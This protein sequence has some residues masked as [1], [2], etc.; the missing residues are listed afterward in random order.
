MKKVLYFLFIFCITATLGIGSVTY[1]YAADAQTGS[2]GKNI[3]YTL[4]DG[5]LNIVGTGEIAGLSFKNNADVKSVIISEG[6]TAIGESAFYECTNLS[7]VSFPS[8]LKTLCSSAFERCYS[9]DNVVFP[10]SVKSISYSCFGACASCTFTFEGDCPAISEK[11]FWGTDCTFRVPDTW[12]DSDMTGHDSRSARYIGGFRTL[13]NIRYSERDFGVFLITGEGSIPDNAFA[14]R[15]DIQKITID[16]GITSVGNGAFKNCPELTE[17]ILL[18]TVTD[19]GASAFEECKKLAS[20]SPL[21]GITSIGARA[22]AECEALKTPEFSVE[23]AL[24]GENAFF[25]CKNLTK[26]IL[27]GTLSAIEREAFRGC[28]SLKEVSIAE[29]TETIGAYAFY[30]CPVSTLRLPNSVINIEERAF[31]GCTFSSVNIPAEL[32]AIGDCAF[33]SCSNLKAVVFGD[34]LRTIGMAAFEKCTALT[35]VSFNDGLERLGSDAFARCPVKELKLPESL[36]FIGE[37]CFFDCRNVRSLVIPN[38][39][40]EI[41][42]GAFQAMTNLSSITL[43]ENL[44]ELKTATFCQCTALKEL[45]LPAS[46]ERMNSDVFDGCTNLKILR[47]LGT[48]PPAT[49]STTF[50]SASVTTVYVPY[51]TSMLYSK[52]NSWNKLDIISTFSG[53]ALVPG[54][55]GAY[56]IK[57]DKD[58]AVFLHSVADGNSYSGKTIRLE[59]DIDFSNISHDSLWRDDKRKNP[60]KGSFLGYGHSISNLTISSGNHRLGLFRTV[61]DGAVIQDLILENVIVEASGTTDAYAALAGYA[62]GKIMFNNITVQSGRIA[63][64]NYVGGIAGEVEGSKPV[65]FLY[66]TNYA[67]VVASNNDAAGILAHSG[68]SGGI[69]LDTCTNYGEI[70][71]KAGHSGGI[72]GYLGNNNDDPAQTVQSCLNF[73]KISTEGNAGG[74]VGGVRTDSKGHIIHANENY[75]DVSATGTGSYAGGIIGYHEGGGVISFN[76]SEANI[77]SRGRE[78]GGIVAALEDDSCEFNYNSNSGNVT[79]ILRVGGII[80]YVGD[81]EHD[82]AFKFTNCSNSGNIISETSDAGGIIGGLCTDSRNHTV[83]GNKN[84]GE[85]TGIKSVGGIIG[86]MEGGG[87]I[88]D[89]FNTGNITSSGDGGKAGGIIGQ[90]E[91]DPCN[92]DNC[93]S[94]GTVKGAK[95]ASVC[96]WD[97]CNKESVGAAD[98]MTASVFSSGSLS[99]I[100][101]CVC[102]IIGIGIGLI[103]G[104]KFLE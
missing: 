77:V 8:T 3:T 63:G 73:G 84:S 31:T 66:C 15:T 88:A 47:C 71:S 1:A 98:E 102:L 64:Y 6:I 99:I 35:T 49:E 9:I 33:H 57:D 48:T 56:L 39:V 90:V 7:R 19:I 30:N 25:N 74:I 62:D 85:I 28:T 22:F 93:T 76:V 59:N 52:A 12:S 101:G 91:D 11:A 96:G 53:E 26:A 38:N 5:V 36:S 45:T 51:E 72:A 23:L 104:K 82:E 44:R 4:K 69:T 103:I 17:V 75:A 21:S 60:F 46:L 89:N 78:A 32:E 70:I 37:A 65:T 61:G 86:W 20:V 97:G 13:E 42:V 43:P 81:N 80:G 10:S 24:L 87:N 18:S 94:T 100:V 41:G 40:T 79:G 54:A 83:A 92:F 50:R 14:G 34:K 29:G 55:D 27:P 95:K 67:S 68:A 2:C 58:L 16:E